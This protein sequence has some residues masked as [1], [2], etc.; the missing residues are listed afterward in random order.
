MS[1]RKPNGEWEE[2]TKTFDMSQEAQRWLDRR[3]VFD[4]ASDYV[5][6]IQHCLSPVQETI[7]RDEAIARILAGKKMASHR[8]TGGKTTALSFRP[9]VK[10]TRV[11]FSRG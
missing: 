2:M 6:V 11:E 10:E 7:S 4:G 9:K 1:R 8:I 3:L 5:G